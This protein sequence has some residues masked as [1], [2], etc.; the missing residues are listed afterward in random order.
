MQRQV[1]F[2]TQ[3]RKRA[4]ADHLI[5]Y[6]KT[7][8]RIRAA[9]GTKGVDV[10]FDPVGGDFFE[11]ALR[12]T[13]WNGQVQWLALP[14]ENTASSSDLPLLKGCAVVGVFWELSAKA[15]RYR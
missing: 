3:S 13:S 14:Q 12:S 5:N 7:F 11:P 8:V 10:V 15:N 2:E 6:R 4:G 1:G 9:V